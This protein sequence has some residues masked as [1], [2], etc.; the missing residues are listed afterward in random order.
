MLTSLT[1]KMLD[2]LPKANKGKRNAYHDD[3]V[4]GLTLRVTDTGVKSFL[5]RKRVNGTPRMN[6]IGHYPEMTINQAR[7]KARE[8]INLIENGI[9]PKDQ[10]NE[11]QTRIIT[12]E[13]VVSDYMV[14]R[15]TNLKDNT[16][17]GYKSVFDNYLKDW[18]DTPIADI[19]GKMVEE[20][21]RK[22]TERSPPRANTVMRQL[23]AYFNYAMGEYEDSNNRPIFF[24]NPV[25]RLNHIK[26]WNREKRKQTVIK[27]YDLKK[28]YE[29]VM[30]LPQ[31]QYKDIYIESAE[32]C[33][34]LFLFILFT[35]LRRREASTLKWGDIDFKDHS[36]TIED[37]KNHETHSLPL[38]PFLLEILERR[39][40]DSPYIF[41]GATPDKP[42]NDPKK[43]VERVRKLSG[44]Y[45][46]LHDLRRTFITIAESLDINT[47]ALKRLLNHKDQRDVT[48]GYIIT[49]MER[50]RVPMNKIANYILEQIK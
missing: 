39:K 16:K 20:R 31:H 11:K 12:L 15:G 45:F 1:I 24:Y 10:T 2:G 46:N 30:A 38:T 4:N 17:K 34:D 49:D 26:A 48:G 43:Q 25:S 5:V 3:K 6:T 35:G 41:Q 7:E 13:R 32:V 40:S 29:A 19:T 37:T 50:L 8:I 27:T 44:V 18:A 47:Y 33:R 36:L 42:I 28:W 21:H 9:N 23:R 14:S 22:I